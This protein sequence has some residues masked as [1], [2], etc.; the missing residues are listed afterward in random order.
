MALF[1]DGVPINLPSHGHGQGFADLHFLIPEA[2]D[3]VDVSKGPYF[4]EY[5]DFDTAGA[6]NLRTRRAFAENSLSVTYGSFSSYRVLGI[7][8]PGLSEGLPWLAAEVSGT[9]GP[10]QAPEQLQR[11]N[12]FAK[13]SLALNADTTLSLLASLYGSQWDSSGQ[14]PLRAVESGS[15]DRFGSIDPSEGGQTQRQMVVGT[16]EQR[17]GQDSFLLTAYAVR[18]RVRLFS[19]F[20][21]QLRDPEHFDEIE[22]ND[23]RV[24]TG[25]NARYR[26]TL[27]LGG[28][29]LVST[30][31]AQ[32]RYDEA[33]TDLWHTQDRQ[34][35]A[36]C[37]DQGA[38]PCNAALIGETNLAAYLEEDLRVNAWLR[39]VAGLRA[40]LFEFNVADQKPLPATPAAAPTSGL[41]QKSLV[42]PKLQVVLRPAPG[43]DLYLDGGGGFHS[44][45][46]RGVIAAGGVGALPR[47]WGGEVGTRVRLFDRLDVAAALWEL[48]LQ[49]EQV[50]SAD[51]GDT[52]A[53]EPTNRYGVDF[54][55]RYRDPPLAVGGRRSHA[56]ARAV[57]GGPRQRERGGA[58]A[59][60]HGHR[61]P[62]R[63]PPSGYRGRVGVRH[64]GDRPA[65]E[66]GS[67]TA[68]GYT[69]VDLTLGYRR[70]FWEVGLVVENLFNQ[71]WRE[72]QFANDSQLRFAPYNETSPVSD[73]H[74]TPGNP[75]SL[76]LTV[77]LFY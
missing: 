40:D 13:E 41:V 7:A 32:G 43:W 30:L 38:N 9:Q 28:M 65:S 12:V 35:L 48:Y 55:V 14:L 26:R 56:R 63:A 77:S 72:A 60:P 73:V 62:L 4:A 54:E 59:H 51:A 6:V 71:Q 52:E 19:D 53:S 70:R 23:S 34:R 22:Q 69:L 76:R 61:G 24:Y 57:H 29:K 18:Y 37:F 67:L 39:V 58:G 64:V 75:T 31:G 47:A 46:A 5:G 27:R 49:S 74:F 68:E 25:L 42:S 17:Q 20:T 21:Y 50:F 3:R 15:L 1:I 2:I 11:Y 36:D 8:S 45:D 33:H 16:L 10:F 44:N 66:D